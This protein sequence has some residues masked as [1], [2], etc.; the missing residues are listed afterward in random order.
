MVVPVGVEDQ[1][2]DEV[3]GVTCDDA[4]VQL[5]DEQGDAG[6]A[7]GGADADVVEAAVVAQ[8]DGA[9]GVDGVV[10]DS[11]VGGNLDAVGIAL[12]P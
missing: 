8:G 1:L 2:P 9:A 10:A 6:S 5:V 12:A 11:V 3:A 7:V 4:N